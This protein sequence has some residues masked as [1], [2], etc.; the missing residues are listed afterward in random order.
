MW[1]GLAWGGTEARTAME[2]AGRCRGTPRGRLPAGS[3][4]GS[5][6][7]SCSRG[8]NSCL[9][10]SS[11]NSLVARFD[12]LGRAFRGSTDTER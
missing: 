3:R 1:R 8:L 6:A 9:T 11:E 2:V 5:R 12:G 7:V 10:S 4:A